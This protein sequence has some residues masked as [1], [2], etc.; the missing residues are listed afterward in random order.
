MTFG[1]GDNQNVQKKTQYIEQNIKNHK[2]LFVPMRKQ[3]T[4]AKI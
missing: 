1:K 4:I 3:S 2:K